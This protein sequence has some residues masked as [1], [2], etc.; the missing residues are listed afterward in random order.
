VVSPERGGERV[1]Q[2]KSQGKIAAMLKRLA[3]GLLTAWAAAGFL[4]EVREAVAG[5]D[6]RSWKGAGPWAWRMHTPATDDLA[7]CLRA[8][9]E[10][11]PAGSVLALASPDDAPE[12]MFRRWRWAAYYLPGHDVLQ[13]SD[14]SA[15]QVARYVVA[16]HTEIQDP[17]IEPVRRLPGGWL[18]RVK[19]P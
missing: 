10:A 6:D 11:M 18:Y 9:R 16:F 14:P 8:A 12:A 2:G 13:A 5:W 17:R 3:L 19:R 7:R 4:H 1:Y 15:A